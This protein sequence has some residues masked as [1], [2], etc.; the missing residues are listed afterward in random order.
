MFKLTFNQS[1]NQY[2]YNTITNTASTSNYNWIP[3]YPPVYMQ[4]FILTSSIDIQH[5]IMT[6]K[7]SSP[8]DVLPLVA[9]NILSDQLFITFKDIINISLSTGDIP[10]P[11]LNTQL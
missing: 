7:S 2:I 8:T 4:N 1:I 9:T 11:N 3:N 5:I 6:A 10:H